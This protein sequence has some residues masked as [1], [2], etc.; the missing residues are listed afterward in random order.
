M[1]KQENREVYAGSRVDPLIKKVIEEAGQRERSSYPQHEQFV[2]DVLKDVVGE[3]FERSVRIHPSIASMCLKWVGYEKL[4]EHIPVPNT[5]EQE[6]LM[7]IG[8]GLHYAL[9]RKLRGFG[10]SEHAFVDEEKGASGRIDFL[11]YNP[12]INGYHVID[13]KSTSDFRFRK[14]TRKG[15]R[16]NL[17]GT[18][19]IY[20]PFY[21][22]SRF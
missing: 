6:T 7:M 14:V 18:K 15:L 9:A 16:E 4:G 22:D 10:M 19:K 21:E 13:F 12:R 20:K 2:V 5:P 17:R 3:K 1:S 11:Y 8:S